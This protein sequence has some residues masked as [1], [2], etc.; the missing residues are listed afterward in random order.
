MSQLP[1]LTG[2]RGTLAGLATA[3]GYGR[4]DGITA[5]ALVPG[6]K[7]IVTTDR[8][9]V[10]RLWSGRGPGLEIASVLFGS[11]LPGSLEI[12]SGGVEGDSVLLLAGYQRAFIWRPALGDTS[13]AIHTV[14][15]ER[16]ENFTISPDGER[17]VVNTGIDSSFV[18]SLRSRAR[19]A[20][21]AYPSFVDHQ[22]FRGGDSILV[23]VGPTITP[24]EDSV[25][26]TAAL[27]PRRAA[28][29]SRWLRR[30]LHDT[31]LK[32]LTP[33]ISRF[34]PP[35]VARKIGSALRLGFRDR[36]GF[37]PTGRYVWGSTIGGVAVWDARSGRRLAW[38]DHGYEY[39]TNAARSAAEIETLDK[40]VNFTMA[41]QRDSVSV[42]PA[43]VR[44]V[45]FGKSGRYVVTATGH[46]AWLW[47]TAHWKMSRNFVQAAVVRSVALSPDEKL[48][49]LGTI[50]DTTRAWE[51]G[52]GRL[53]YSSADGDEVYVDPTGRYVAT[54]SSTDV[55]DEFQDSLWHRSSASAPPN[56][57]RI[58]LRDLAS[59][60]LVFT[61]EVAN[62]VRDWQF[63]RSA[64]HIAFVAG[65]LVHV[66]RARDGMPLAEYAATG[67]RLRFVLSQTSIATA[68][69]AIAVQ[70][71]DPSLAI[72]TACAFLLRNLSEQE[73]KQYL[74]E[75]E[76]RK[77]CPKLP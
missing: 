42:V 25:V 64:E 48:L 56:G 2:P 51:T 3:I 28:P 75:V 6:R 58:K 63:D 50:D 33:R 32:A 62:R 23:R 77:T 5:A 40:D 72:D 34:L 39:G 17:A 37:D 19:Q 44:I 27:L 49:I 59:R 30:I 24:G 13:A 43:A 76:P 9:G 60:R 11:G 31:A 15:V 68:G 70:A 52:T 65:G 66:W 74:P 71:W 36:V 54:L 8:R 12:D 1:L 53:V 20:L 46:T 45:A 57:T 69:S 14:R 61:S 47:E 10:I 29:H 73:W 26:M 38:L 41:P 7:E 55:Y 21:Q 67:Y 16:A 4:S 35:D 22:L 18:M